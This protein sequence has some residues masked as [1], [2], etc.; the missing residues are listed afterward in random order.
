MLDL[1]RLLT[2][3]L[4]FGSSLPRNLAHADEISLVSIPEDIT[5]SLYS[6]EILFISMI[7]DESCKIKYLTLDDI[8]THGFQLTM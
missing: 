8:K 3:T 4:E 1:F 5:P 2:I 7:L 6:L